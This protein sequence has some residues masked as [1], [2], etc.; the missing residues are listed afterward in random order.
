[1]ADTKP[2]TLQIAI[3]PE[4][5]DASA[6]A[7]QLDFAERGVKTENIR[8]ARKI[9]FGFGLSEDDIEK[10]QT[11][12]T[13]PVT[14]FSAINEQINPGDFDFLLEVSRKPGVADPQGRTTKEVAEIVLDRNMDEGNA[15]TSAQYFVKGA[16]AEDLRRAAVAMLANPLIEDVQIRDYR[17]WDRRTGLHT[18]PSMIAANGVRVGYIDLNIADNLLM[19][20]STKGEL[21]LNLREMRGIG[22]EYQRPGFV[23]ER[24]L[25]GLDAKPTDVELEVL[26]QTWSE[27]CKHKIFNAAVR[28]VDKET[29]QTFDVDS[30]FKT[31]IKGSTEEIAKTDKWK[32]VLVSVFKDN[33]GIVKF[34]DM[35]NMLM[36]VETHNSPSAKD[37][38]GGALTGVNGCHRDIMGAGIGAELIASTDVLCFANPDYAGYLPSTILHPDRVRKGVFKGIEHAGNKTG[39]PT[40][41]GSVFFHDSFLGKPLVFCGSVGVIPGEINGRRTEEKV[42]EPGYLAVMVGGR[43]GK[44]GIHGATFSSGTLHEKSPSSA[45]QIGDP[46]VQKRVYDFLIKARDL[47]LFEAITDNG[48]GGLSS[49]IG[50]MAQLSGGCEIY[51]DRVPLKYEGMQPREILIS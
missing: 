50:E 32:N 40:V 38:Y 13:D 31:F 51:L 48:A 16:N 25:L 8:S 45:V 37:P 46:I 22:G 41:N 34:N 5:S 28:Y 21:A 24:K 36:K 49:S 44:D 9:T 43:V 6:A 23:Q 4:F 10:L 15:Y 39:I 1:M 3:K 29:G 17:T 19:E 20:I 12:L 26:A 47:G 14:E 2:N 27:H 11:E 35:W 33:A 42:I 7:V 30:L 18:I